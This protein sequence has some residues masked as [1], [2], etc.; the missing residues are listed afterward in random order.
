MLLPILDVGHQNFI[1]T[2]S[3]VMILNPNSKPIKRLISQAKK[4]NK[5]ID[6]TG[7]KAGDCVILLNTNEIVMSSFDVKTIKKRYMTYVNEINLNNKKLS[8]EPLIE[9]GFDNYI[10]S[11]YVTTIIQNDTSYAT[12]T[13]KNA[14]KNLTLIDCSKGKKTRSIIRLNNEFVISSVLNATTIKNRYMKYVNNINSANINLIEL[15][16][17]EE[18]SE[19][20]KEL[21]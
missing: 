7:G 13:I 8:I 5:Y 21:D 16:K 6:L 19:E 11:N 1:L 10:F 18:I 12:N 2:N 20:E 9:I 17:D 15:S 14:K 4:D 3:I